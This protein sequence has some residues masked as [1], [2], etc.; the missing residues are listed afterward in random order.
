MLGLVKTLVQIYKNMNS[1]IDFYEQVMKKLYLY[2]LISLCYC[3]TL[4]SQAPIQKWEFVKSFSSVDKEFL[5]GY[6][7]GVSKE[8]FTFVSCEHNEQFPLMVG[9]LANGNELFTFEHTKQPLRN[10][11]FK[12]RTEANNIYKNSTFDIKQHFGLLSTWIDSSNTK[13]YP[14][15]I[16]FSR[17]ILG[18]SLN[19]NKLEYKDTIKFH[20]AI[21][22]GYHELLKF[23]AIGDNI[24]IG[25]SVTCLFK[26]KQQT[27]TGIINW[28][29][30]SF[31]LKKFHIDE[32]FTLPKIQAMRWFT[33][34]KQLGIMIS[35]DTVIQT[36]KTIVQVRRSNVT[37]NIDAKFD[38][39]VDVNSFILENFASKKMKWKGFTN[40]SYGF[41][42][43]F[44]NLDGANQNIIIRYN[45]QNQQ[46]TSEALDTAIDCRS[47]FLDSLGNLVI[48]GTKNSS[49][50]ND[51]YLGYYPTN[52]ML[53]EK[54]WG[55]DEYDRLNDVII[56]SFGEIAVS[57]QKGNDLYLAKFTLNTTSVLDNSTN[58]LPTLF[59]N[60]G[61]FASNSS[62]VVLENLESGNTSIK[63]FS[64]QGDK[65]STI[66]DGATFGNG[67]YSFPINIQN[68]P[69]GMYMV[70]VQNNQQTITKKFIHKQ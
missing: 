13:F 68:L 24:V 29:L 50:N 45:N 34:T 18:K 26:I 54:S 43:I 9:L 67:R 56:D 70:V 61:S 5:H 51:F 11:I 46:F 40:S 39:I 4:F 22:S 36:N 30:D 33:N 38:D 44:E 52:G 31:S 66:Y 8:G 16:F 57:G 2:L 69:N 20:C 37:T 58:S 7:I 65:I 27:N 55:S 59:V 25:D 10:D 32:I 28:T 48:V 6:N 14:A 64:L 3:N 35:P 1:S 63:L 12:I 42:S 62:E 41:V 23:I 60:Q 21:N 49:N 47:L 19:D 53:V 17:V 15:D